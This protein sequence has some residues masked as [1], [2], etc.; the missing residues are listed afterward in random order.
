LR[1]A[2]GAERRPARA[3]QAVVEAA[4]PRVSER[5]VSPWLW[6]NESWASHQQAKL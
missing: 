4:L 5:V 2:L 3:A 1:L 6:S